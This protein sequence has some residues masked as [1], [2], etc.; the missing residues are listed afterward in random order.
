MARAHIPF[1]GAKPTGASRKDIENLV[2]SLDDKF[3]GDFYRVENL[4]R[5]FGG[6][7][8]T[9]DLECHEIHM[10]VFSMG[11]FEIYN[12][13]ITGPGT[14]AYRNAIYLGHYLLHYPVLEKA[15]PGHGMQIPTSSDHPDAPERHA[16][17]EAV[18]F[19]MELIMP[20]AEMRKVFAKHDLAETHSFF[21]APSNYL[22]HRAESL[23]LI[24][25]EENISA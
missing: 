8:S 5:H 13:P 3:K 23:G 6:R 21:R 9:A 18:W 12:S 7:I 2:R 22:R 11:D 4:I 20:E 15:F 25:K 19:A 1:T 24:E 16:S 17:I 10:E 14:D